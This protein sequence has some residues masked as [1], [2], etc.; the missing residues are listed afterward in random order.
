MSD[1]PGGPTPPP[2]PPPPPMMGGPQG[3]IPPKTLGE[4]LSAAF[5]IYK[6]NIAK[7][8]V[9]VAVVVVPLSFVST[10]LSSVVFAPGTTRIVVLGEPVDV[11]DSRGI[12]MFL[13]VGAIGAAIS[14][15]IWAVL[16][17]AI[18]RAAAQAT[19]GDPVDT[20]ASYRYGFR[21]LG[22]V[23]LV[24]LLVGLAVLGGLI[25]LVIPGLIF[26]VFL[27][28]SIPAL[29]VEDRR[30]IA[31]MSR[32]WNLVKGHFWHAVGVIVV[33]GLIAGLS[34]GSS[35]RSAGAPGS[36]DGSSPRSRRSSRRR[37]PRSSR[38]CCT[39]I[40][41]PGARR[42]PPTRFGQS[43]PRAPRPDRIARWLSTSVA[44]VRGSL[45]SGARAT[46]DARWS[47]P[48]H[49]AGP[50]SR[51]PLSRRWQ[52]ICEAASRTRTERSPRARRP[53]N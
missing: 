6:A 42:C 43:S 25:L 45:R 4:I 28:V 10:L 32:S 50:R 18:L 29:V 3:G 15:I 11:V 52:A 24:S 23:I 34:A 35:G 16:E 26:I 47:T 22:S 2:P 44:S 31:A 33:A 37:S 36:S 49:Q 51:T 41:G 13:L 39:W 21:R 53:T 27:S 5:N 20:E 9:I 48:M 17:A 30:G 7:L 14:V 12:F 40:C 1:I 46:M 8:A 38:C 19:I